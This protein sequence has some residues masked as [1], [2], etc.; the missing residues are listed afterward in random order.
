MQSRA[1]TRK[2]PEKSAAIIQTTV[3]NIPVTQEVDE[4]LHTGKTDSSTGSDVDM[5]DS[6]S[7]PGIASDNSSS[8]EDEDEVE[9][10]LREELEAIKR[11]KK[12]KRKVRLTLYYNIF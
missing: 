11:A 8:S 4:P 10:R 5:I 1:R 6:A 2:K 9:R 3:D 12:E 7:C